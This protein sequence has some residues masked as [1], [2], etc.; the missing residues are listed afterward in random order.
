MVNEVNDSRTVTLN[1][2]VKG[3]K[4]NTSLLYN[5]QREV[6]NKNCPFCQRPVEVII[7]ETHSGRNIYLRQ[8]YE[9]EQSEK[10]VQHEVKDDKPK[11]FINSK[12]K[13]IKAQGVKTT[14][15]MAVPDTEEFIELIHRH[16]TLFREFDQTYL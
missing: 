8:G 3:E 4:D 1:R 9:F 15:L 10:E 7:D 2:S 12:P 5:Y 6:Y 14:E 13:N 11:S 16:V